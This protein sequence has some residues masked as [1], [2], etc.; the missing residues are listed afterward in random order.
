MRKDEDVAAV[1][2]AVAG[3][4]AVARDLFLAHPEGLRPV[5]RK[6]VEF[7]KGSRVNQELD[8][9]ARGELAFRVLFVVRIAAPVHGI[10]LA[11]PEQVDLAL[12]R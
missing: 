12:R 10:V 2:R 8:A 6:G 4:D 7:G 3:D 5:H 11:L 1:D 9:L